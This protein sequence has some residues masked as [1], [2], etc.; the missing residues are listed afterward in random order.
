[1][2]NFIL[3]NIVLIFFN[4]FFTILYLYYTINL[5]YFINLFKFVTDMTINKCMY[6]LTQNLLR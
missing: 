6:N 2:L 4:I 1:M 3:I 5:L